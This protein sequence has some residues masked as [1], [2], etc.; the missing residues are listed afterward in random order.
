M[1]WNLLPLL[2]VV[3]S[4][5]FYSGELSAQVGF[6]FNCAKDTVISGCTPSPCFTLRSIIPD[7]HGGTSSYTVSP[8]SV[9]G[10]GCFPVYSNPAGPGTSANLTID[11]RYTPVP[12]NIGFTFPFYGVNYTQLVASTNG[13][14]S[15]DISKANLFS[16]YGILRNG[17]TLSSSLGVPEN[18]P[19]TLYDAAL[20]MGPYHDLNPAISQPTHRIEYTVV[21]TAPHRKW[22]LSYFKLTLF[23]AGCSALNENTHQIVLYEST[24]I[25]EVLLFSKQMCTGWNLGRAIVGIQNFTK[26]QAL[27][28]PGRSASD[29]PWGSLNM[30]EGW[31][32][33]P[34]AGPSLFKRVEL[35]NVSGALLATGTTTSAGN[36]LLEASFPNICPPPG[37]TTSYVIKSFY[38]KIDDPTTEIFGTDTVRITKGIPADLNATAVSTP[39]A[40]GPPS[41]SITVTVPTGASPYSYVLDNGTPVIGTSPRTFTGIAAGPHTIVVTDASGI[42]A[43][44]VI[45]NVNQINTLTAN[46]TPT[47]TSCPGVNNGKIGVT[48]TNGTGPYTFILNPG[49]ITQVGNSAL[50]TGLFSGSYT[51]SIA[52]ATGCSAASPLSTLIT[53]SPGL[54]TTAAHTDALCNG[55]ANG[56]ITVTQPTSGTAPYEYSLNGINWQTSNVFTALAAGNYTVWFRESSGCQGQLTK[57]IGQPVALTASVSAIPV[58]C[59]GQNN[60]TLTV[61][62]NGG[63]APYEYSINAGITWQNTNVF[64]VASGTYTIIVRDQNQC[65]ITQP[66]T[67]IEPIALSATATTSNGTCNGG[68]DGTITLTASGGNNNF[69]YSINGI[70]FQASNIFKTA[71]GI[72]TAIVRDNLG[73][74]TTVPNIIVGATNDLTYTIPTDTTIC[75][76]VPAQ[77]QVTSNA[78]QYTWS[79][80]IGLSNP[81]VNNPTAILSTTT[82]YSVTLTYGNCT[83]T[84]PVTVYVKPAPI[85]NAGSDGSICYGQSFQLQGSGGTEFSWTPAASLDNAA[86]ANP[87]STPDRT[88]AYYLWVKA[89][90]GCSSVVADTVTVNLIP[91]INVKTFPFDTIVYSGDQFRLL[92]ISPA[93]NY[94]WTPSQG[95]SNPAIP[96]PVVTAGAVGDVVVYKVT[97]STNSGCKGEGFVRVEVYKGPDL[98]VPTGFTPNGDGKN[99][100]FFPF[101][102]GIKEIRSFKVFNRWGQMIYSTSVLNEGWDGKFAGRDQASGVYVWM[103]QGITK[104]NRVITKRGTVTLVR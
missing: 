25:I 96:D 95:L 9:N 83:T 12:L 68:N 7:I 46:L 1:R 57:T 35:Y 104:D 18:L 69:E 49:A 98:Y 63:V 30:N 102:V 76:G 8:V 53:E 24:G 74:T 40:C 75:E 31:R 16:H 101:P 81:S 23:G 33:I 41:G 62:P 99:D 67:V 27:M 97:T 42:C 91:P 32:F 86:I 89:A 13:F 17:A 78:L 65:I 38:T 103:V 85:A 21:G 2:F 55:V 73:C 58:L 93:N 15:F 43:S 5:F 37:V 34:A 88:T 50:F 54:F 84:V 59:N 80:A 48:P 92:A 66:I 26:D 87:V 82:S 39:S 70:T 100:K 45:Q 94:S 36:G 72:Y 79:P 90:N 61:T 10:S 4:V 3:S 44:T 19:S 29:A 47:A 64:N 51:V 77:L 28:A 14:I 56:T 20:I 71:P 22:I 52:D 6:S 60:G 11:D